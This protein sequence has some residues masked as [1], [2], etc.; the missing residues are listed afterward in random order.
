MQEKSPLAPP[1]TRGDNVLDLIKYRDQRGKYRQAL[2]KPG[3][4][5]VIISSAEL[6]GYIVRP[7]KGEAEED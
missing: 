5:R 6:A 1:L 4:P 3:I 2:E 7:V